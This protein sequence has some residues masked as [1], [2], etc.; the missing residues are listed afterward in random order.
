MEPLRCALKKS[1]NDGGGGGG[2]VLTSALLHPVAE[3]LMELTVA[4]PKGG[5]LLRPLPPHPQAS[6]QPHPHTTRCSS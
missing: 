5:L 1:A 2:G 4:E 3:R 6:T